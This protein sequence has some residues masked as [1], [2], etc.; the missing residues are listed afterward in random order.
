MRAT[1]IGAAVMMMHT[2]VKPALAD[3]SGRSNLT[4]LLEADLSRWPAH[5]GL[6]GRDELNEFLRQAGCK[7][8]NRNLSVPSGN[9][10]GDTGS[11]TN[12]VGIIY[13]L[14]GPIVIASYNMD[15]KGSA[16]N[17]TIASVRSPAASSM[18]SMGGRKETH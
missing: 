1:V 16:R 5:T 17:W 18:T 9:E 13:T 12:D 10:T 11:V 14:S 3:G 15:V 8:M 7:V 2:V 4:N 6:Y